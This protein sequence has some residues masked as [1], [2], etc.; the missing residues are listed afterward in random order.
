MGFRDLSIFDVEQPVQCR[1]NSRVYIWGL[2]EK[3]GVIGPSDHVTRIESPARDSSAPQPI[4]TTNRKASMTQDKKRASPVPASTSSDTPGVE[5]LIEQ[6]ETV[7]ASLR[8]ALAEVS[9][10]ATAL[11]HHRKHDKFI[12]STLDSLRQ[13][14]TVV[15]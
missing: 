6:T 9:Q 10:L 3:S 8:Q 7:R 5:G 12:R 2:L 4:T 1:D 15:K 13:L 14:Q 11:R